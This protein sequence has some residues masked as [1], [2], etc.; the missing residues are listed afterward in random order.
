M[1]KTVIAIAAAAALAG[2]LALVG[3]S[4]SNEMEEV[5]RR[6]ADNTMWEDAK[7]ERRTPGYEMIYVSQSWYDSH[8]QNYR[9]GKVIGFAPKTET[10]PS[11]KPTLKPSPAPAYGSYQA[12]KV[13]APAPQPKPRTVQQKSFS[14]TTKRSR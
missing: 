10:K 6:T 9:Y 4:G 12:P 14:S 8:P 1:K 11:P 5:C 7:C 13:K 2:G 3:C